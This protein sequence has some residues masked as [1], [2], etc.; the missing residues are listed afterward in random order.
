[1]NSLALETYLAT[2]YT[3]A[4]ARASFLADPLRAARDAGLSED[5]AN[6]LRKVDRAGLRMAAA[7]YAHKRAQHRRP[8][9]KLG[10]WLRSWLRH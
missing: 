3:D 6:A 5:D 4:A 8:K 2:L 7:S 10:E 9:K 1:M